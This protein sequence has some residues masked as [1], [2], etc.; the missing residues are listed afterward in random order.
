MILFVYKTLIKAYFNSYR[1]KPI[2]LKNNVFE[3][4]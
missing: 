4:Y 3:Y 2:L 1:N